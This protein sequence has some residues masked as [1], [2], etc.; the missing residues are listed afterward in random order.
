MTLEE[1]KVGRLVFRTSEAGGDWS[2]RAFE[3]EHL[4]AQGPA[5]SREL[6]IV[7]LADISNGRAINQDDPLMW[8]VE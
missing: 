8:V 6:G 4:V 5:H 2:I 1:L 7:L 3:T